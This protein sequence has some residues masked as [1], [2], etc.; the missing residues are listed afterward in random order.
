MVS[1]GMIGFQYQILNLNRSCGLPVL[2][3]PHPHSHLAHR[4]VC[5]RGDRRAVGRDPPELLDDSPK[6]YPSPVEHPCRH[7]MFSSCPIPPDC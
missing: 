1:D 3:P 2:G 6:L 7:R 4:M 5:H